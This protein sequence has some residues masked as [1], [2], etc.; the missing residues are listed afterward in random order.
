MK[1]K[2]L[3]SLIIFMITV[4]IMLGTL[5]LPASAATAISKATVTYTQNYTYTGKAIKPAVTVKH[6]KKKLKANKDYTVA[7]KN[8]KNVGKATVTVTGKGS[9]NGKVTKSFYIKPKAVSSLKATVYANKI[10]LT[11]SKVTGAKGY[12]VYQKIDGSWKKVATPTGTSVTISGLSGA[13]KYEFRVRAYAKAGSKTLY[14]SYKNITKTTTLAKVSGISASDIT[15]DTATLKWKKTQGATSY[16]VTLTNTSTNY[17]RTLT[18]TTNSLKLTSLD[19]LSEYSVKIV[20]LNTSKNI[21]GADS[22]VYSFKTAPAAVKDLTATASGTSVKLSWTKS[23]GADGYQVYY[24]KV[25]ADGKVASFTKDAYVT[26]NSCTVS[27]LT[28]GSNYIFKVV[29]AI[30]DNGTVYSKEALTDKI[31]IPVTKVSSFKA[32]PAGTDSVIL[33]WSR[34][35]NID[36]YKIYKDGS[37]VTVLEAKTTTYT[38]TGLTAGKSYKVAI[39]AYLKDINGISTDSEKTEIT[40]SPSSD[41]IQSLTFVSRPSSLKVGETYQLSVKVT[42]ENAENKNVTYSSSDTSVATVSSAGLITAVKAGT[43]TIKATSNA[44]ASKS[45]SFNLTVTGTGSQ[46]GTDNPPSSGD[47]VKVQSVSLKSEITLYEGDL[48]S[49][50]PTFTPANA[51]DK[52][53]TVTG[54]SSGSYEFSKYISITS[55]NFLKANKATLDSDG[56]PFYFTVTVKTNDGNKT[57]STRVKVE[58]RMIFVK[59]NGIESSPWYYGNSAK[60]SVTLHDTIESKYSLSDIR[61]KSDNTSLATVTND[62]TVTCKGV[63]EVVITAYTSDNKYSGDFTLYSRKAVSVPKTLYHSCKVGQTYTISGTVLPESNS[64]VLVY[65]SGDSSIATVETKNNQ[66]IVTFNKA[67]S[68][69]ISVHNTSDP[70]NPKQVWMTT[71]TPSVPSGSNAQLLSFARTKANALKGLSNLPSITRYDETKTSNFSISS[72]KVSASDLQQI[73]NSELAPKTTYYSSVVSS[74]SNY[75][76]LKKQFMNKVP[77]ADQSYMISPDLSESDIKSISVIN[78]DKNYYYDI[79]LTLKDESMS[80]LPASPSSTRHGKV[81]DILTSGIIDDKLEA[82]NSSGSMSITYSSFAQK[83]HDSTLTLRVNKATDNIERASYDMSLDINIS[84]LK[85]KYTLIILPTTV[86][87]DVSFKCNNIVVIDFKDYK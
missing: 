50:N 40:V 51:T 49:L 63:G 38:L 69:M 61:F 83:Y 12:Q 29:A 85:M 74:D 34:P 31:T 17:K 81:F 84:S 78:D 79:K 22:A 36:G 20:A 35:S 46:G 45:V 72:N 18:A 39:C 59:Y 71:D 64:D 9:Y 68:V 32:S 55:S 33:T 54:A 87:M 76:T 25:G 5:C 24:G 13:T 57:A 77:V 66:G 10:K 21:T 70:F 82:V 43:A 65:Y 11:W 58:P 37:L 60:L 42:P 26:S 6:G 44:D 41:S 30:I 1:S 15:E 52:T 75:T 62:G 3:S 19:A 53:Y 7:Y 47:T 28:P 8:N 2:K 80:S 48:I 27:N 67:G 14:S 73:F 4:I 16:R 23:S 86:T 56:N